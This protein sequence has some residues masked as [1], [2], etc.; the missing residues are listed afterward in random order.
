MWIC[1]FFNT[2][3]DFTVVQKKTMRRNKPSQ[4]IYRPG[5]G[6]LRKSNT[7]ED[8]ESDSN[9]V[10]NSIRQTNNETND[11]SDNLRHKSEGNSPRDKLTTT[12]N[13]GDSSG[14][15]VFN[16]TRRPK[17]PEKMLYVPRHAQS[18]ENNSVQQVNSNSNINLNGKNE[19]PV[20]RNR[21]N[22]YNSNSHPKTYLDR[23]GESHEPHLRW[24]NNLSTSQRQRQVSE[25]RGK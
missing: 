19:P 1:L 18:R 17:K 16:D 7:L 25:P 15:T 3:S 20:D 4:P 9:L 22:S 2:F 12:K 10:V 6:P 5:N 13:F 24:D 8:S 11:H 14:D 21:G 23:R